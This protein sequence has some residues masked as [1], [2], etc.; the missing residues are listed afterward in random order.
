MVY[1]NEYLA[2]LTIVNVSDK[3]GDTEL[4]GILLNRITNGWRKKW[5]VKVLNSNYYLKKDVNMFEHTET[6][7][8][9]YEGVVETFHLKK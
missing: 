4:N 6:S 7:E 9:V 2:A 5:Y 1:L 8:T 3:I